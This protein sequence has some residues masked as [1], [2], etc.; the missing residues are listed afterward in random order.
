M[1]RLPT[2]LHWFAAATL[3]AAACAAQGQTN[4]TPA[5]QNARAR[6]VRYVVFHTAGPKWVHGKGPF[7]QE[8]LQDHVAHY[9]KLLEAGQLAMGGPYMDE[10]SGGMMIPAAGVKEDDVKAFAAADPAVQRGL[11]IAEVRPWFVG[12]RP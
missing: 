6:D 5:G 7:E 8:G 4:T 2:A 1:R 11:L 9:R 3:L 10:K 12:L